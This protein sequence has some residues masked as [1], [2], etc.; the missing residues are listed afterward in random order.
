MISEQQLSADNWI[1]KLKLQPHPEGGYYSEFYR[2]KNAVRRI[3]QCYKNNIAPDLKKINQDQLP[4]YSAGTSIYYLLNKKDFS[5]WHR[6]KS[7][8]IWHYYDGGSPIDVHVIDKKGTLKTY[9]VGNPR[10]TKG[11]SFQVVVQA[12]D[13]FAAEV[14]DKTTFG[15]VGCTVSPGFE[16]RDFELASGKELVSQYPQHESII[17]RLTRVTPKSE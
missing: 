16:F 1:K 12:G 14:R 15:L 9:I 5:A 13:W 8:E 3:E 6:I 17:N 4:Q 2:A 11:A 10:I 7:D